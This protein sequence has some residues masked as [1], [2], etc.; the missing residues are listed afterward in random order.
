MHCRS[1]AEDIVNKY[2]LSTNAPKKKALQNELKKNSE[3]Q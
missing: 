1:F 3:E 2:K